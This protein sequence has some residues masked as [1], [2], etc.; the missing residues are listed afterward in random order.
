MSLQ[1]YHEKFAFFSRLIREEV[2]PQTEISVVIPVYNEPTL[3]PTLRALFD[4]EFKAFHVEVLLVFNTG[5][6]DDKSVK[7]MNLACMSEA[8][9]FLMDQNKAELKVH[10]IEAFDLPQKSA[11]VGLARKIGMDEAALRFKDLERDGIIVGFDA[12]SQCDSNYL[13]EIFRAFK[14]QEAMTG[15]SIY[16]EHPLAGEEF[17]SDVYTGILNYEL[18]LR[19][20]MQA[21]RYTGHP[22]AYH[23][24]GSSFAVRTSAYCKQGGMNKRK[25]GEDFYFIQKIITLGNYAELNSTRVI[26][27]PRPS[28]RVPF[29]T[30][31][32]IEKWLEK[33]GEYQSY[34]LAS[35][36]ELKDFFQLIPEF[37]LNQ[38]DIEK[39]IPSVPQS[40]Q[41]FLTSYFFEER[42]R[43]I[44]NNTANINSF[45]Q[46]FYQWF[47]AFMVLK[48]VHFY[49]DQ[50]L[51][52]KPLL[53][54]ANL[55]L[56]HLKVER[57]KDVQQAL[58]K[59]RLLEQK[60]API[61][62]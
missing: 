28:D 35:F 45:T 37:Y 2:H 41:N 15:C 53:E 14:N 11:G 6:K 48:F 54:E 23:T 13:E 39:V 30:G 47:N 4:N 27:S 56:D 43:E 55:L 34:A 24:V 18:H 17:E 20:Y 51:G 46:R 1:K 62:D 32:A 52:L 3:I 16:F 9:K 26:P 33:K 36:L 44:A 29:G 50:N 21:F 42:L 19:Y 60:K 57:G 22:F 40:L 8:K 58:E 61:K 31:R 25:A 12:D 10:F 38:E 7:E 49:R 5:E 59:Y